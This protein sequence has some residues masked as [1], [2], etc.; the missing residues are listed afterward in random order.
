MGSKKAS[1]KRLFLL[2]A[3]SGL[4][5]ALSGCVTVALRDTSGPNAATIDDESFAEF[6]D[7]PYPAIMTLEKDG[8]FSYMRREAKAGVVTVMGKMTVDELGAFYDAHLPGHGWSPVAEAQSNKLVSTW[9]K[10][11]RALTII[12]TPIVMAIGGNLRVELWVG[13]PHTKGDLGHRVVY[14]STDEGS[15]PVIQTRPIRGNKGGISEEDI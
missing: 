7:V 4:T 6:M 11:G 5:M 2:L 15:N 3:L 10:G 9:T 12:A 13:A 1:L 8:T 14:R